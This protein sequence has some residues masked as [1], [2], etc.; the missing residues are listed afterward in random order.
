MDKAI[1]TPEQH[2]DLA[3]ARIRWN[4][5][6]AERREITSLV[7][8]CAIIGCNAGIPADEA[9][10]LVVELLPAYRATAFQCA[11]I[12]ADVYRQRRPRDAGPMYCALRSSTRGCVG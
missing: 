3:L 7:E 10:A 11:E 1:L 5:S 9:L 12:F 2:R 6:L 8:A 4:L